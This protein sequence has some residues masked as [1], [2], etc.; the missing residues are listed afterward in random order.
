MGNPAQPSIQIDSSYHYPPELLELLVDAIPALFRSKQGVI[1]FFVGAGVHSQLLTDW[2]LRLTRDK[3]SV[4]KHEIARS[5][6]CRLNEGGDSALAQRREVVKRISEFEDFSTC[7]ENDRYKAQGLVAQI[8]QVVH[9][10]DSFTRI[11]LELEKERLAKRA[12]YVADVAAK[13]NTRDERDRVRQ[14]LFALFGDTNPHRRGK[15]LESVLNDMFR[16]YG[17]L[18]RESFTLKGSTGQGIIEQIDGVIELDCHLY[19]VEMKWLKDPVGPPEMGHHVSRLMGRG[20]VK[21]LFISASDY[22][23]AA[24]E[25]A[26]TALSYTTCVLA[27]LEEFVQVLSGD[28]ELADMLRTKVRA[29]MMEKQPFFRTYTGAHK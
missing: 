8:R 17:I 21:G 23:P 3:E 1:D 29:A 22:T 7:W 13:Q 19:L 4:K 26:K 18:V 20:D 11:Q 27:T 16:A 15:A 10:K 12:A 6:L 9:V 24:I 14:S 28:G 5:V 2:R 25:T